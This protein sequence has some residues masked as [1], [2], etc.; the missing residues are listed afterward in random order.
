MEPLHTSC[1]GNLSK[2]QDAGGKNHWPYKMVHNLKMNP[3]FPY[4][5]DAIQ[6]TDENLAQGHSEQIAI[7][8]FPWS[9]KNKKDNPQA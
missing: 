3:I 1:T 9:D 5:V 2:I 8:S 6:Y 4:K 7:N